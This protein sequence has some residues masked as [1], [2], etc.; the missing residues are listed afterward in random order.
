MG[1]LS[2][3]VALREAGGA[4]AWPAEL[5]SWGRADRHDF[6]RL[7]TCRAAAER[8]LYG[9]DAWQRLVGATVERKT[10]LSS[11]LLLIGFS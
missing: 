8:G 11:R 7:A 4:D 9:A 5:T 2:R 10:G 3:R 1:P 6:L